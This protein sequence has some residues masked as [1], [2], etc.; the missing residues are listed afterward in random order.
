MGIIDKIKQKVQWGDLLAL[1]ESGENWTTEDDV[2]PICGHSRDFVI[3]SESSK[4]KCFGGTGG[5]SGDILEFYRITH[6]LP[7]I[8]TTI[9][10]MA[11]EFDIPYERASN[12][13]GP[14]DLIAKELH[15]RL[16]ESEPCEALQGM[17]PLQY[18]L[19]KRKHTRE[20]LEYFQVGWTGEAGILKF[21]EEQGINAVEHG[22]V[23]SR[24]PFEVW[25]KNVFIYPH[26]TE[27]TVKYFTVKD[28]QKQAQYNL[29]KTYH[30]DKR[31]EFYNQRT[32]NPPKVFVVEGEND[33][34]SLWE[35]GIRDEVWA[36][37]GQ[38]SKSQAKVLTGIRD[39]RTI[40]D[41]DAAGDKYRA[42]VKGTHYLLPSSAE[43][44]DIDDFLK[45]EEGS[46]T[47]LVEIP[48]VK[49]SSSP[50]QERD[51][52][53]VKLVAEKDGV[54]EKTLTNFV[55]R[56]RGVFF[57]LEDHTRTREIVLIRDNG[58]ESVPFELTSDQKVSVAA[59]R[60]VVANYCD[61]TFWGSEEDLAL[62]WQHVYETQKETV[63]YVPP[64]IGYQKDLD[65]WL[66]NNVLIGNET[67]I[68]ADDD[69]IMWP[70][71]SEFGY[72]PKELN[73]D[74]R[75]IVD[76]PYISIPDNWGDALEMEE[77]FVRQFAENRE[78]RG[79]AL[80]VMAWIRANV[81]TPHLFMSRSTES[82]PF[83][84]L[85]GVAGAGKSHIAQW[86]NGFFGT[87]E[88]RTVAV[89]NFGSG[90]GVMRKL[91]YYSDM[92]VLF[93]DFRKDETP[94][95]GLI[96]GLYNREGRVLAS[97]TS[98]TSK[99][100]TQRVECNFIWSGED[101]FSNQA[102]RSRCIPIHIDKLDSSENSP[103][104]R[105]MGRNE[106]YFSQ[107]MAYHIYHATPWQQV[108]AEMDEW[109]GY[110]LRLGCDKRSADNWRLL[111]PF[112]FELRDRVFPDYDVEEFLK[113][114]FREGG[115][116]N[117]TDS[118]LVILFQRLSYLKTTG[119]TRWGAE[120]P[121]YR[122]EG[123][124]LYLPFPNLVTLSN[125]EY[126]DPYDKKI[127]KDSFRQQL[128]TLPFTKVLSTKKR[129]NGST[130]NCSVLDWT[131]IPDYIKDFV[132]LF[133]DRAED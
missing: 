70:P 6:A 19:E 20:A 81:Y 8:K 86:V 131:K 127:D 125:M 45:K 40:F 53:Y 15:R 11:K 2:C 130:V 4:F 96:R 54:S 32:L 43:S 33:V 93:D 59:F 110:A 60:R 69:G 90:A 26:I 85:Y 71:G 106:A 25:P 56:L 120:V 49:M 75:S 129:I 121:T 98:T 128:K 24:K 67:L 132:S 38:I 126:K 63:I 82:F 107:V 39:V 73:E 50:I 14:F 28:P 52:G 58:L 113:P 101:F 22:F 80:L 3:Y 68:R 87:T 57:Y 133:N 78:N 116:E 48:R 112:V 100:R 115:E 51:G 66:F 94:P 9:R 104:Y 122:L 36:T 12:L 105:W 5:Q 31:V 65:L 29:P 99:I 95:E 35:A 72:K 46:L 118:L 34:I 10:E 79:L 23:R 92:P 42:L 88:S 123:D 102:L 16:L 89:S 64:T 21:L 13:P 119:G 27:G 109:K 111:L 30:K 76:V 108:E 84:F 117:G 74:A 103:S 18:Q 41:S 83:L 7:D 62:L 55:I 47:D 97:T 61:G 77:E 91:G 17:T 124:D 37:N 1:K 44:K 114:I